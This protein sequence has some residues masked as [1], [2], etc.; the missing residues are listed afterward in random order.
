MVIMERER[1][2][3]EI[4][5]LVKTYGHNRSALM[6]V[7]QA[8]QAHYGSVSDYAM[9]EVAEAL[10]IPPVEVYSTLS[11]YTFYDTRP[12]G[13]FIFRLCQTISCDMVG[14]NRVARQLENELGIRFG[15]TTP[16]GMFSLEY[17]S[18]LGMCD[19]G[20]ALLV[21]DRIYTRVTPEMVHDIVYECRHSFG[22]LKHDL[23]VITDSRHQ[24]GP[25]L[26][27]GVQPHSGLK[28]ALDLSRVDVIN[29]I[30]QSG[31]RGRG[32]AGF[33]TAVKWQLAAA[34]KGQSKYV[35]CNADEG[36]PG[37]FKDRLLLMEYADLLFDGMTIAG[38]AIGA[39]KGYVYLRGEYSFLRQY[40]ENVLT[41]RREAGLLGADIL[42]HAR[43]N[44][45]IQIR[46]GAGAYVCGEETALIESLEGKRGEPRN[47]PPF[48]VN[49]GF[50]GNPT[51]VNNVET[52][53]AAALIMDK[54]ADWFKDFGTEK[55]AGTKLFSVSGD[56][57]R[58]GIY[59]LPLG[60]TV[61][62]LLKQVGGESA[63]AVQVGGASGQCV[64][65]ADF[66][67]AIAFED[68][69]SG[70]SII[71]FGPER[72]MLHVAENFLEFFVEESCGQCF[73]CRKGTVKLLDGIRMLRDG[74]CSVAY[75]RKLRELGESMQK[76]SKCGLGQSAPN[77]FLS[78]IENFK[79]E[80]LGRVPVH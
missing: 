80:I 56:C 48:P 67:R 70:G 8:I 12:R 75:L 69:A 4:L 7:L 24:T 77:A 39:T 47:R 1:L 27:N 41:R 46:M 10:D 60:T 20:P 11:F 68:V 9:Q 66:N 15:D 52:F 50:N 6:P 22:G 23:S 44:F 71:V 29:G 30:R 25:I 73:P 31:L 3:N 34:A 62:E 16:D 61:A 2:R 45:D 58:P 19:Q 76:A 64:A 38:Y 40:L 37:T 13:R 54:G 28:K 78:I 14:K 51:A 59:E 79:E 5:E 53:V 18:C 33:P 32:G 74:Q 55:S 36:E 17:A 65:R 42:G 49:T 72:D 43:L 21:N 26:E 57:E 63:K 35:V